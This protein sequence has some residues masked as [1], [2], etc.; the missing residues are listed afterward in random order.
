MRILAGDFNASLDHAVLRGLIGRGY[1]DAADRAG[2]GLVPTW[3]YGGT[4]PPLTIDHVLV[5]RRCAVTGYS[6]HDIAGT[7][8]RAVLAEIR[9]P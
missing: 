8:H 1:A 2:A 3:G 4:R 7:D 6:V 5:D 9:L